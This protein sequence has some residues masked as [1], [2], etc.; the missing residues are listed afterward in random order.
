VR[1]RAAKSIRLPMA[2]HAAS[3]ASSSIKSE[4]VAIWI[5]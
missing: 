1:Q 4:R 2:D 5:E 3:A